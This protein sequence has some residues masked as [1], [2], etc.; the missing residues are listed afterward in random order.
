[1]EVLPYNLSMSARP[2]CDRPFGID[3]DYHSIIILVLLTKL[4]QEEDKPQAGKQT[5]RNSISIL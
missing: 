4:I 2:E 1:M 5:V 3:L